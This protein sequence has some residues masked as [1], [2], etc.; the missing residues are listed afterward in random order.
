MSKYL[1]ALIVVIALAAI[2][3]P[4]AAGGKADLW[5]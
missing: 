1:T 3:M 2:A 5:P 4:T